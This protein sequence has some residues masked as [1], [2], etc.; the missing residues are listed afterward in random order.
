MTA[1]KKSTASGRK[2]T[3]GGSS[4]A[5]KKA[6]ATKKA[7]GA[8]KVTGAK[9]ATTKRTTAPSKKAAADKPT[10]KQASARSATKKQTTRPVRDA[11]ARTTRSKSSKTTGKA[12]GSTRRTTTRSAP[13]V[14]AALDV[15]EDES[16]WTAAELDAVRSEL[17]GDIDRL[18]EELSG[19]ETEILG[20]M[21]E[22]GDGPGDDQA[23]VG[24]K[25][26][27]REH[28]FYLA[29]NSRDLMHQSQHAL[30]RIA[31]GTYGTCERC[32]N[33]IGKMRLQA[34]PRA[35]LCVSCKQ[36]QERLMR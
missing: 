4:A 16:P 3:S 13:E 20:L 15:R 12:T 10:K 14:A 17:Q 27:E 35:T 24:T 5:S 30:D 2:A 21:S 11:A 7:T 33:P 19:F 22:G 9:K 32:G 1:P 18:T 6:A 8:K 36:K 23:D 29:Q 28:E 34:F 31:D 25:T 26:F